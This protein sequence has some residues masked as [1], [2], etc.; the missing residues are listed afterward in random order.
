MSSA[1][2][3]LVSGFVVLTAGALVIPGAISAG[4]RKLQNKGPNWIADGSDPLPRPKPPVLVADGSDPLP[5]PKPPVLVAD[6]SDP[7]PRPKPP[8]S[9]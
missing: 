7:L 3:V 8:A 5:R 1:K 2:I 4:P 9:V 6:G